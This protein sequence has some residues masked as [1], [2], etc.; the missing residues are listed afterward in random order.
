VIASDDAGRY[1]CE[2]IYFRS[3]QEAA[4][5]GI[6][7]LFCHVPTEGKPY[8]ISEMTEVLV[9]VAMLMVDMKE[10]GKRSSGEWRPHIYPA[11]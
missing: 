2:Y 1:L 9:M 8:D 10:S 4:K 3:M 5:S 6:P 7:V 11:S